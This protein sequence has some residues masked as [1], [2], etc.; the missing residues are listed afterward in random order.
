MTTLRV[1]SV[2]DS[3]LG[4]GFVCLQDFVF[5]TSSRLLNPAEEA[6]RKRFESTRRL[7]LNVFSISSIAEIG[8]EHPGLQLATERPNIVVLPPRVEE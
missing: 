4:A 7:H 8:S 2:G 1:R 3:E 5:D 6:L